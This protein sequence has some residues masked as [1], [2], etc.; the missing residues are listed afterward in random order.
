MNTSKPLDW[1]AVLAAPTPL[2][3]VASCLDSLQ[4]V[5]L[6]NFSDRAELAEALKATAAVPQLAG[7]PRRLRGRTLVDAAVFEPVPVPSAIRDGCTHVLVLCTRPPPEPMGP[8]ETRVRSTIEVGNG[9]L[10]RRAV[11][12]RG[13][14]EAL[15]PWVWVCGGACVMRMRTTPE[16]PRRGGWKGPGA[17][18][19]R[20]GGLRCGCPRAPRRSWR[21]PPS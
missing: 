13:R 7:P 9:R 16:R 12:G 5:L 4:P 20:W 17:R 8:W 2:K 21:R 18:G 1:E 6:S 19:A 15:G 11:D 14:R 3:V 10:C